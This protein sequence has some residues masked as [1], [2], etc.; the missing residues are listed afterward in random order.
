MGCDPRKA[1][2][3]E[4]KVAFAVNLVVWFIRVFLGLLV[5]SVALIADA[6]H[7][8]TDNLTTIIVFI[9][10]KLA[11]KPPDKEHPYGHGKIADIGTLIMSLIIL[12]IAVYIAYESVIRFLQ[13]YTYIEEYVVIAIIAVLITSLMKEILARYAIKLYRTSNSLLCLADA[14]HHRI[15]ALTGLGVAIV[16]LSISITK[17]YVIDLITALTI[18]VLIFYEGLDIFRKASLALIDTTSLPIAKKINEIAS[19]IEGIK[20]VHDIRIRNYGGYYVVDLK[21]HVLP[22]L[23]V[24]EAHDLAH[25]VE[26]LIKN[27]IGRVKEVIVHVEPLGREER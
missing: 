11:N 9:S 25:K 5:G 16:F 21:I 18:A 12:L 1:E 22:E 2:V 26:E 17:L 27:E 8:L 20:Y 13:G 7:A 23:S 15:D 3:Q 24:E 14:W 6:W 19:K 4:A 10:S